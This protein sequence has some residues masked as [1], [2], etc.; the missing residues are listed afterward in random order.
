MHLAVAHWLLPQQYQLVVTS[1]LMMLGE[2]SDL[3]FVKSNHFP[4]QVFVGDTNRQHSGTE[5]VKPYPARSKLVKHRLAILVITAWSLSL[6]YQIL[7]NAC[8]TSGD[9]MESS[10]GVGIVEVLLLPSSQL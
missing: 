1:F 3:N 10:K 2:S 6:A 8:N 4:P 5:T 7:V 9:M